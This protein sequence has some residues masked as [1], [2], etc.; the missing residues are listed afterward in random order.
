MLSRQILLGLD[1]RNDLSLVRLVLLAGSLK[2]L[3]V[4]GFCQR[5]YTQV[6]QRLPTSADDVDLCA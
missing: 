6:Q 5:R 2:L 4:F 3:G 1:T